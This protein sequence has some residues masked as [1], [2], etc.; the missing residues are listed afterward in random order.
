M[1][2]VATKHTILG[3]DVGGTKSGVVLGT[4]DG[5]IVTEQSWPSQ[6]ERGPDAMIADFVEHARPLI[7]KHDIDACGVS[8]GGPLNPPAGVIQSPPHLPGWDNIPLAELLGEALG[9]RV[10]IEHDAAA[11]LEAEVLWGAAQGCTH[12]VY[13]TCGTGFGA[14]ILIDGRILRGPN[15]ESPEIG[16]VRIAPN[17][18][19]CFDV[20][21]CAES[22]CS[23]EGLSKLAPFMFPDQ[24]AGPVEPRR[25]VELAEGGDANALAVIDESG[26][27]TGQVCAMVADIFAPQV[28][29]LGS[30]SRYL[31]EAWMTTT[32]AA[33]KNDALPIN[34]RHTRIVRPGLGDRLQP[35]SAIA[36][37][38]F[39]SAC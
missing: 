38:V 26:R 7:A 17:G 5:E 35:L 14:G 37:V 3:W 34:A 18:P 28:I 15:G 36:P 4:A 22:F 12:A 1:N 6:V 9:L 10:V 25:L 24:F 2:S 29:V 11:C 31:P 13:C 19:V 33:F 20:A 27:R 8:I 30:L 21:G 16:H 32:Q 23:G 39:G